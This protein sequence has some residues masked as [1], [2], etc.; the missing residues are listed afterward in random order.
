MARLK[1][2]CFGAFYATLDETP[3]VFDTDKARAL[4]VYLAIE[5]PRP[6]RRQYL[7]GLFWSDMPEER[8]LHNLRQTLS[9]L[10]KTLQDNT[11]PAPFLLIQRDSVQINPASDIWLDVSGFE[12][13]I[14]AALRYYRHCPE[15][16]EFNCR[17]NL[18]QLQRAIKLFRG[19]F[20]DQMYLSGSPVFDEWASLRREAF[21]QQAIEAL[22]ILA[23]L[24]ERRGEYAQARQFANQIATLAPWDENAQVQVMRLLAVESQWSAAQAQYRSLRHYLQEQ[25]GVEPAAE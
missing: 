11:N 14:N 3:L 17:L 16:N 13:E 12:Q 4:L 15:N 7:A 1:I 22:A 9:V 25:I 20:L 8:A 19:W 18:R 5:A 23:E 6:Q 24:F 21:N 2:F 10:R